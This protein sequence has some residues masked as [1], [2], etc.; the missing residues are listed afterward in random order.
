MGANF[1]RY[2]VESFGKEWKKFNHADTQERELR[3]VFERY[4]FTFP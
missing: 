4:F 1:D 2:V 3:S